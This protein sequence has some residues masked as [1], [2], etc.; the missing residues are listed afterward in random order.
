MNAR[1][2]EGSLNCLSTYPSSYCYVHQPTMIDPDSI[3][4]SIWSSS[5][6]TKCII[7]HQPPTM[8]VGVLN[9]LH[10]HKVKRFSH[11]SSYDPLI[12]NDVLYSFMIDV[13]NT[14]MCWILHRLVTL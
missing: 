7:N 12:I 11:I 2:N 1:T 5:V 14:M 9:M 4:W 8:G 6:T 3:Q 13:S 10:L